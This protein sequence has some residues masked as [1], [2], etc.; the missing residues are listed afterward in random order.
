[1]IIPVGKRILVEIIDSETKSEGIIIPDQAQTK[2]TKGK[3]ISL[4]QNPDIEMS[5]LSVGDVVIFTKFGAHEI[6][7]NE[8]NCAIIDFSDVLGVDK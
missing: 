2:S 4:P 1:M 5:G 6:K 7:Q 3:I 8:K